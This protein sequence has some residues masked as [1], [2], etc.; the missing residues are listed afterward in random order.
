MKPRDATRFIAL[1]VLAV[2]L[3]TFFY[4]LITTDPLVAGVTRWSPF[5]I[6]VQMYNGVLPP[7]ICERCGEP[8]IRALLA[9][10]FWVIFEYLLM[11]VALVILGL[12]M[13]VRI[14][15]WISVA[16]L[17]SALRGRL[18]TRL[19]FEG[20]F[21]GL[22]RHGHVYDGALLAAHLVVMGVLFLASL[23][24]SYEQASQEAKPRNRPTGESA[25]TRVI[26]AEIV[27][28]KKNVDDTEPIRKRL[29]D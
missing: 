19:E 28:E 4:P 20:T 10:P 5:E 24:L 14:V 26:D 1:S 22:S 25:E 11:V 9:V 3:L 21:F 27:S 23:D 15:T 2:G 29:H 6:V 13:P 17:Y 16:A 12:R 18:S 8:A 7:P